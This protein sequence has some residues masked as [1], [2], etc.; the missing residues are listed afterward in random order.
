MAGLQHGP[1]SRGVAGL[2]HGL[3]LSVAGLQH[4][5]S[6]EDRCKHVTHSPRDVFSD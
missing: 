1:S 2:Q 6:T 3:V 4:G 5:P